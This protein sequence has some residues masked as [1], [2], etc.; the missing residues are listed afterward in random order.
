MQDLH[1]YDN[2]WPAGGGKNLLQNTRTTQTINDVTFT[3]NSDGTVSL[4]GTAT[5]TTIFDVNNFDFVAGNSYVMSGCP[6][7]GTTSTYLLSIPGVGFD[8]GSGYTYSPSA[9][10]TLPIRITVYSGTNVSGK[11]FKPMVCLSTATNPTVFAP[12]SNICPIS[13]FTGLNV[14]GTGKNLSPANDLWDTPSI[15]WGTDSQGMKDA[16]NALPQGTYTISCTY[17]V[18]TLPD[19]GQ[20]VHGAPYITAMVNGTQVQLNS[21]STETDALPT[22]GK[23][24]KET[25]TITIMAEMVGNIN[26]CYFY[27]D[28]Y[29]NHVTGRG[30]Y[31][32]FDAQIEL[33]S[34]ATDFAEYVGTTLPVSW[35]SE[36]G[37]VYAGY[38]SIDKDGNTKVTG[39]WAKHVFDGTEAQ[40]NSQTGTYGYRYGFDIDGARVPTSVP[41][42][43]ELLCNMAKASN[44]AVTSSLW[45]VGECEFYP[46]APGISNFMI[47]VPLEYNTKELAVQ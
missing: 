35:Q 22:V 14:Y 4:S 38:L 7:G 6:A 23:Q 9:N 3:I 45:K 44:N 28:Q 11:V 41:E 25:T 39:T 24:Y 15:I 27:C 30:T 20:V 34:E 33:G 18:V 26:H 43:L 16:L 32:C 40:R 47:I 17:E 46:A 8:G 37:T 29:S 19:N 13:G 21:Y 5:A 42:R 2:P 1:G 10:A 12:Y 31:M 36:A